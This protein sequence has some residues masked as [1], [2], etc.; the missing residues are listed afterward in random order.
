MKAMLLSEYQKLDLGR[1]RSAPSQA[2]RGIR[3]GAKPAA[4]VAAMFMVSMAAVAVESP[5]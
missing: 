3:I 4:F 5:R 2:T 1:R